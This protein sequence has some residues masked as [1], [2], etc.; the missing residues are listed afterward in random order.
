MK[1]LRFLSTGIKNSLRLGK[2]S[3][4]EFTVQNG[5]K[6]IK[7]G[8]GDLISDSFLESA[9]ILSEINGTL[10]NRDTKYRL[11]ICTLSFPLCHSAHRGR[12]QCRSEK[13]FC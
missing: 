3:A 5:N 10:I 9:L 13:T 12:E 6:V 8:Q 1:Q 7:L 11:V 2:L 4:S